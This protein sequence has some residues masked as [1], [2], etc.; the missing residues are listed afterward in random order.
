MP[1]GVARFP[2]RQRTVRRQ[3]KAV[4]CSRCGWRWVP[5]GRAVPARCANQTCRSPYWQTPRRDR[6]KEDA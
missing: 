4:T 6:P 3:R 1:T 5:Y 2:G